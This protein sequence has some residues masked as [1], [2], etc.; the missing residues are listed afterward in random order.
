MNISGNN[1]RSRWEA[2]KNRWERRVVTITLANSVASKKHHRDER[3]NKKRAEDDE[4]LYKQDIVVCRPA[5]SLADDVY[6][7]SQLNIYMI[8]SSLK[9]LWPRFVFFSYVDMYMAFC[10]YTSMNGELGGCTQANT[11]NR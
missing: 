8:G 5:G 11:N 4:I 10:L 2:N 3:K 9:Y 7:Y 1:A 6:I